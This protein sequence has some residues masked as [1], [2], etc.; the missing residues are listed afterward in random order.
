MLKAR[1][2]A[3]WLALFERADI[4]AMRMQ[5]LEDLLDDAHLKAVKLF[6]LAEHPSE[7]T[8]R[9]MRNP[10]RWSATPLGPIRHAPRLGEHSREILLEVG[11][12]E[13]QVDQ[14]IGS[15]VTAQP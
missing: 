1:T 8:I 14:L 11:Y 7:G 2:T 5:T 4:P 13:I 12:A 15:G 6:E 10:T 9:Q 3:D